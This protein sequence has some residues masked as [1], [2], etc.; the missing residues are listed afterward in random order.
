MTQ[1]KLLLQFK[2][3]MNNAVV[4][5]PTDKSCSCNLETWSRN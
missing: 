4:N 1:V 5:Y 3:V 2:T